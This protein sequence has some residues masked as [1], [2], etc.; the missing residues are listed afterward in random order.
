MFAPYVALCTTLYSP[1]SC[2]LNL[3]QTDPRT[4]QGNVHLKVPVRV[5]KSDSNVIPRLKSQIFISGAYAMES[6]SIIY[7]TLSVYNCLN[8][9]FS[10]W[11]FIV[12][13]YESVIPS[14]AT[15]MVLI[16]KYFCFQNQRI[17]RESSQQKSNLRIV[18]NSNRE[19]LQCLK[20]LQMCTLFNDSW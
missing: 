12:I 18:P 10:R 1:I 8:H 17:L 15:Q 5:S 9:R 11:C 7:W 3:W 2:M 6:V 13:A 20:N 14:L 19:C 16:L 4:H